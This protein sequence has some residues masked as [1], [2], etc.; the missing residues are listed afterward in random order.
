VKSA[1]GEGAV[2]WAALRLVLDGEDYSEADQNCRVTYVYWR[3]VGADTAVFG[4]CFVK[5]RAESDPEHEGTC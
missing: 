1:I 5:D 4:Y 3:F 2:L